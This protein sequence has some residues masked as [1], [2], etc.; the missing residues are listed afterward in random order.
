MVKTLH[1]HVLVEPSLCV[2]I[3]GCTPIIHVFV[4]LQGGRHNKASIRNVRDSFFKSWPS[5]YCRGEGVCH[6]SLSVD[7]YLA[8]HV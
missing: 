5:S 6:V 8:M 7:L 3:V 4:I 1:I 2:F